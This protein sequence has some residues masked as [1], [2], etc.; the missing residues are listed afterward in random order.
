MMITQDELKQV[1]HYD[2]ST[3]IWTWIKATGFKNQPGKVAGYVRPDGYRKIR[4]NKR[5]YRSSRLAFLYMTGSFPMNEADHINRNP[6]DDRWSNL[7]DATRQQQ[8]LN[9]K[10]RE[11]KHGLPKGVTKNGTGFAAT[12][13][14]NY[15][16]KHYGTYKTPEEA[17]AAYLEALKDYR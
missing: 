1:L 10:K 9:Q 5:E 12:I 17:H 4:I 8:Q 14:R 15:K 11:T 13:T 7:R 2:P 16:N 3:G 6:R